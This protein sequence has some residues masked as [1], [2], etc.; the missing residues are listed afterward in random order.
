MHFG[1]KVTESCSC[2][3]EAGL[4]WRGVD[5]CLGKLPAE[6]SHEYLATNIAFI[7]VHNWKM[8]LDHRLYCKV[9]RS[10]L[11]AC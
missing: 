2:E 7:S 6:G 4:L 5:L 10:Y 11:A 3:R 9:L 8:H 1:G